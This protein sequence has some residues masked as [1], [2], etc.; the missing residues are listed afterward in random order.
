MGPKQNGRHL[1]D[2][3]FECIFLNGNVYIA[4]KISLKFDLKGPINNISTLV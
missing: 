4:I 3:I 2:D 1:A